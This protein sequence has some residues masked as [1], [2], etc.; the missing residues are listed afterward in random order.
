[1]RRHTRSKRDW[2]SD[3]CSSD[4][5]GFPQ[6]G[7]AFANQLKN[8]MLRQSRE[9]D[10]KLP[11]NEESV[12]ITEEGEPIV[13]KTEAKESSSFLD[14]L[15]LL[16]EEKMPERTIIDILCNV[17]YWVNWSRHFGPLSGSDPK[18]NRPKERYILNTFTFGCNL[19]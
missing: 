8:W 1:R 4:L 10:D 9:V 18:L 11:D 6:N 19:G 2:S 12:T 15:E 16:I 17:E 3:V 7:P 13:R 5:M 14:Q